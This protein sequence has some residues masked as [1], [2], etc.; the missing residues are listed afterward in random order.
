MDL[1]VLTGFDGSCPH[2]KRG[3]KRGPKGRF[4]LYPSLRKRKGI[5]EEAPGAGSRFST[6][7]RNRGTR[8]ASA[9]LVVD[10]ETDQRTLHHDLGYIRHE[11]QEE[12]TMVPGV[13][14]GSIGV[15]FELPWFMRNTADMRER[16]K[17]AFSALALAV[18][19]ELKL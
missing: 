1:E 8:A 6:R 5:S 13:R 15:N 2:F 4:T 19:E 3:V 14:E 16:G 10:W 11:G 9:E 17:L 12:W 7:I 18:V